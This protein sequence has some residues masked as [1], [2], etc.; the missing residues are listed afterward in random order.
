MLD[1]EHLARAGEAALDLIRDQKDSMLS[2]Q[3]P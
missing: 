1:R 2:A 3:L